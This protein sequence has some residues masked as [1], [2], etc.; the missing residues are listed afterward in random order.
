MEDERKQEQIRKQENLRKEIEDEIQ[1]FNNIEKD[2]N[3]DSK[4]RKAGDVLTDFF[5]DL[6]TEY[7]DTITDNDDSLADADD[8]DDMV[9]DFK[10]SEP[11]IS[12]IFK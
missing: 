6:D 5:D 7:T 12:K 3:D 4:K 9:E 1:D 2:V 10:T 11:T 8:L